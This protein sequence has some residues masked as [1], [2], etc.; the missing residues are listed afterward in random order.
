MSAY[1]E[2]GEKCNG[3]AF[4]FTGKRHILFRQ[5]LKTVDI[6]NGTIRGTFLKQHRVNIQK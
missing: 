2:N 6:E 1:F 4:W 5:V 3:H